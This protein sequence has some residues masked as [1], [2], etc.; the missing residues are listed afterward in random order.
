MLSSFESLFCC[1]SG[2]LDRPADKLRH[3]FC[4]QRLSGQLC[5]V[6]KLTNDQFGLLIRLMLRNL[7]DDAIAAVH[8]NRE[9]AGHGTHQGQQPAL[10]HQLR[11]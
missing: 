5:Q 11:Q 4:L 7:P 1:H 8:H 10:V 3:L 2:N 6:I 9:P